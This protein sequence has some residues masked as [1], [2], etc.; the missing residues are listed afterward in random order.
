MR[1]GGGG[2]GEIP[3]CFMCVY[4]IEARVEIQCDIEYLT[5][6][7]GYSL[8]LPPLLSHTQTAIPST[9]SFSISSYWNLTK[10]NNTIRMAPA[11]FS[12]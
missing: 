4:V 11:S 9:Y 1:R 2:G 6:D 3:F 12:V 5:L 7:I 10:A 8:L